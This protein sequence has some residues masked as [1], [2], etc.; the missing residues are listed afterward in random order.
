MMPPSASRCDV[1]KYTIS[2]PPRPI[3]RTSAP[4]SCNAFGDSVG[5][6][7]AGQAN[8]APEHNLLSFQEL[9]GGIA[10]TIGDIGVQLVRDLATDVVGLEAVDFQCHVLVPLRP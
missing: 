5:Q 2:V 8:V 4:A 6:L 9:G 1:A 7:C 3:S 10:D